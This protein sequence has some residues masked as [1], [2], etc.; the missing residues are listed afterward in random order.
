MYGASRSLQIPP[1]VLEIEQRQG[2]HRHRVAVRRALG[3]Q[4][5]TGAKPLK[6]TPPTSTPS[7]VIT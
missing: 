4:V 1:R 3:R 7:R 5:E 2:E 6:S